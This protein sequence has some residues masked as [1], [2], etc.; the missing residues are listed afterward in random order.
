MT[1]TI[2]VTGIVATQPN[3]I[4]TGDDLKITS[5]RLASTQRRFDRARDRWVDGETNWYT[6]TTFRQLAVNVG[7][8]V[9][10]GDKVVVTGRL[11]IRD[12]ESGDKKGINVD[13]EADSVGH[14]LAWGT[15][16]FTKAHSAAHAPVDPPAR[17]SDEFPDANDGGAT[18]DPAFGETP[19][20]PAF[21][22]A[23]ADTPF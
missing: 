23:G 18:S 2:A 5:F 8:S 13:I 9:V 22:E 15:T 21:S 1:D 3:V 20:E 17:E 10:K 12:W 6:I 7:T 16:T 4:S 19:R 11:R 14:D